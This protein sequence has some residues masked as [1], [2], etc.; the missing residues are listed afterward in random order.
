MIWESGVIYAKDAVEVLPVQSVTVLIPV[1]D[2][3]K[4]RLMCHGRDG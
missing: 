2:P 3:F 4:T 1:L